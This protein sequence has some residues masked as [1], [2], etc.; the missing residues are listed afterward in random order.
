MQI[1]EVLGSLTFRYIAKYVVVLSASVFILLAGLYALFSRN[2]FN[3]LGSS[4]VDELLTIEIIY[5]GQGL[6]GVE[7]YI[8]DSVSRP[9]FHR[10]F[11]L[12]TD[13]EGQR[14]AGDLTENP[15][16]E[17][18]EDGWLAFQLNLLNWGEEIEVDFLARRVLL[19]DEYQV[20][21]ARDY[22]D[23]VDRARLVILTLFRAMIATVILGG[24]GGFLSAACALAQVE[25]L[26]FQLQRIVRG[27]PRQRLDA[28]SE[29]GYV[30]E[31]AEIVNYTLDQMESLMQGVRNVSDNIAH[32]L[33]TPLTR[34]HNRLSQLRSQLDEAQQDE[35]QAIIEDCDELLA[36]FNAL[37]RISA[38]ESGGQMTS[39]KSTSL[40][41]LLA[42]VAE[43]YDP[44]A[45]ARGIA[46]N[47][48]V[49]QPCE[50]RGDGDLLFQMFA[51]LVDNAIKY[52]PPGSA[53][54]MGLHPGRNGEDHVVVIAD[55]GPGI[56]AAERENVFRR[57]YRLDSARSAQPGHGLGLSLAQAIAQYHGGSV[58]LGSNN[59]GLTVKV[60][61]P[62][63]A[64]GD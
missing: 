36:T 51:N 32:D 4:V 34:V 26:N 21:V 1:R 6:G 58:E 33:R 2:F 22:R 8:D 41:A 54:D 64:P 7:Q 9:S 57:F 63:Q 40:N 25:K 20:I 59:P 30:R 42:D 28:E 52:S 17:E 19:D 39:A 53:I 44:V 13:P 60:R 50:I 61:L 5:R 24:I 49:D 11:Y 14:V 47:N 35:V 15:N 3:E 27:N 43:L 31:L 45:N 56:P 55:S 16:Y 37:L 48:R 23:V 62:G 46:I 18:F 29:K 38:L 10:F 12:V